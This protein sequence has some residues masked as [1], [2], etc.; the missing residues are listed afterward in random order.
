M[1]MVI[2]YQ[3]VGRKS[4]PFILCCAIIRGSAENFVCPKD[5]VKCPESYC[6]PTI[7]VCDG[8]WDCI[9]GGDEEECDRYSCPGQ[10]KCY[11]KS[12]CLPL[13]KLCDGIRNCPHGDDELLCDLDN[14]PEDVLE[15]VFSDHE[16]FSKHDTESEED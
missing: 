3:I 6:L 16:C 14:E 1:F 13:N 8:K 15:E 5:Y 2:I 9:G 7:Y 4:F 11:N 10:Y 12:S